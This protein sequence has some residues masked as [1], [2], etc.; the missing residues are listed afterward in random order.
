MIPFAK[1]R[2]LKNG[3]FIITEL[4]FCGEREAC[5]FAKN[6]LRHF[7]TCEMSVTEEQTANVALVYTE[8]LSQGV[9]GLT[10]EDRCEIRYGDTEGIRNALATF[11]QLVD[12]KDGLYFVQRQVIDDYP[13]CAHR[14]VMIDL[15]RG[16]PNLERL[17][18]D[19]KRL[20]LA[21]CN[22][23]HFH[24]MDGEGICYQSNVF[25]FEGEINGTKPYTKD[26]MRDLVCF[27]NQLGMEIIPEIEFPA[28]A[29]SLTGKYPALKCRTDL[30]NQNG[31]TVC[32]GAE[33]TYAFFERLIAEVCEIFPSKYIHIGGDEHA[34][35]DVPS[36]NRLYYWEDCSV[37]REKMR[38]EGLANHTELFYSSIRRFAESVKKHGRKIILWN[39]E[40]DVSKPVDIPKDCI[41]QFWR[42]ANE[43]RGPRANCSYKKLLEQGFEVICSPFEYCYI[44]LEEY[45]NPEKVACF[46]YKGYEGSEALSQN[47]LGAEV[48]AWEYG[49]PEY[50]HYTY[51]FAP[52]AILLLTKLWDRKDA[53]FNKSYRKKLTKL[54]FG[55][56]TPNNYD[57][58]ELFG[59]IMP[60]RINT[61]QSYVSVSNELIDVPTLKRHQKLL[62]EID[63]TYS[64]VYKN[65]IL[66]LIDKM[67]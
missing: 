62:N 24:L 8:N 13:D 47:V 29:D 51:S 18:E 41:V 33:E 3:N 67:M 60:P 50:S 31:W 38:R 14:G 2:V 64:E 7:I 43:H 22:K 5:A 36:L 59:S 32:L 25:D 66:S 17:K 28:H 39:D 15:A 11:I 4:I 46:D 6:Y 1:N 48:C 44:D 27:C 9:Y 42:I 21:K 35:E 30:P 37:C 52:S 49:N 23:I 45:A 16:L 65:K 53:V 54:I 10:I 57:V 63:F 20:S 56:E 55:I 40:L 26:K 34:F 19:L 61:M 12:V 58:F